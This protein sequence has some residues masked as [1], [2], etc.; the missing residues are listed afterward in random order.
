[1]CHYILNKL[2]QLSSYG[3]FQNGLPLSVCQ[4]VLTSHILLLIDFDLQNVRKLVK[5]YIKPIDTKIR[6]LSYISLCI[7]HQF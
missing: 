1:M 7:I 5:K 2:G 3:V 6:R 4:T